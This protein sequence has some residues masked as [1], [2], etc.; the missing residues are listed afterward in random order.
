MQRKSEQV[1]M[2][3]TFWKMLNFFL[4][5]ERKIGAHLEHDFSGVAAVLHAKA[6]VEEI[7]GFSNL[8]DTPQQ[9]FRD[10]LQALRGRHPD[11][12]AW[13]FGRAIG[14][15]VSYVNSLISCE[16]RQRARC[17]I[18]PSRYERLL[19]VFTRPG[20]FVNPSGPYG[21]WRS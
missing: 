5:K 15:S 9:L 20:D 3:E 21:K 2:R 6:I 4:A 14:Y 8:H 13:D 10:Y 19:A 1:E 11:Y 18:H 12:T 17:T 7:Y 16:P